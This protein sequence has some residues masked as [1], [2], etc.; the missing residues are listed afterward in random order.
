MDGGGQGVRKPVDN[1][2]GVLLRR[3]PNGK[4]KQ[5]RPKNTWRRTVETE[6]KKMR[7]TWVEVEKTP[8]TGKVDSSST[9]SI[10]LRAHQGLYVGGWVGRICSGLYHRGGSRKRIKRDRTHALLK[11][12]PKQ[13]RSY[14]D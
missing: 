1:I 12:P 7:M 10:C 6:I 5:G 8:K 4:R 9:C 2:A 13:D 14:R 3:T 11:F